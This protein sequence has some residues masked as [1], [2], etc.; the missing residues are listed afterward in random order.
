M[1]RQER[2][3]RIPVN[4]IETLLDATVTG[5][6][7]ADDL[8][9]KEI[10]NLAAIEAK[11]QSRLTGLGTAV[12]EFLEEGPLEEPFYTDILM[13]ELDEL[14]RQLVVSAHYVA[15]ARG[16]I[17]ALRMD[18]LAAFQLEIRR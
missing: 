3:G 2:G 17:E 16:Q 18:R 10:R 4:A 7:F 8:L 14:H 11:L 13:E 5:D 12:K 6:T 9:R 15:N 1:A